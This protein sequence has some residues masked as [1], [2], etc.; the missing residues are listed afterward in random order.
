[1]PPTTPIQSLTARPAAVA[2]PATKSLLP[3]QTGRE[4][5]AQVL[6]EQLRQPLSAFEALWGSLRIAMGAIFA[7]AFLDK[8]LGLGFA[9]ERANAWVNG[10]SPTYGF[11]TYG[12][13][14]PLKGAFAAIAG[15]PFVDAIFMLGLLGVGVSLLL[16]VGVRVA[17]HAGAAMMLL[18]WLAHLPPPNNPVLDDHI[19]YAMVL[20]AF[21]YSHEGRTSASTAP[22]AASGS[23]SATACSSDARLARG[24]RPSVAAGREAPPPANPPRIRHSQQP[25]GLSGVALAVRAAQRA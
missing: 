2:V 14:G 7:W 20:L 5:R 13:A 1:M 17:G 24:D 23:S 3:P 22:G 21:A 11:L 10:G 15:N 6:T 19:V 4:A 9:T 8:L 18:M 25:A 16:G 12:T